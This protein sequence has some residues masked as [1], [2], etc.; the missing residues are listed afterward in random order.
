M[1]KANKYRLYPNDSQK[2]LLAKNFGCVRFIYNLALNRKIE[3]YSATGINLSRYELQAQLISLKAEHGWLK[4]VNSQS[5]QYALLNLDSAYSNFFK[6]R[7]NFPKFKK[8]SNNQSFHCPQKV[9]VKNNRLYIP[10]FKS[11]IEMIIHRPLSG[12]VRN[13]TISKTPTNKY[14]VSILTET[15]VSVPDKAS[16]DKKTA[17]GID[18][19]IKSFAVLSDGTEFDNPKY[20][21]NSLKRLKVLQRR[22]SH[23]L[24]GSNNHKKANYKVAKLYEKVTNQRRDFLDKVSNVITKQYDTICIED[25]SIKNMVKNHHL[26]LSISDAGWGMFVDFLE[27]KSEWRG[28]NL[29]KIGRFE[30]S[31]K[32]HNKCGY[33]NKDL[34]LANR[35][36]TC[37]KC[38]DMVFRDKN[39]ALNILD[40]GLL[41]YSGV[42]RPEELLESPT[43]VGAMKEEKFID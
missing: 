34:N 8:K 21:R 23:K 24:K 25:L 6:G 5:L 36:W 33:I 18:L 35:I 38:G 10:K 12:V 27:Y 42:E 11:G 43:L 4:E 13:A 39:A 29:L 20:L 32:T 19:G 41:N 3:T 7:A 30:P 16:V 2:E 9:S 37:P 15:G 26:A 22:A 40:W 31:S 1:L 14:F 28:K 17:I